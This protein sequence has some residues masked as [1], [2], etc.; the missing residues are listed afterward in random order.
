MINLNPLKGILFIRCHGVPEAIF[1]NLF[2]STAKER[3]NLSLF[4]YKVF[5]NI[6]SCRLSRADL[7]VS[8]G[9]LVLDV[10][11]VLVLEPLPLLS[12]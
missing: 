11:D 1:P 7:V 10:L 4:P 12:E 6:F 8:I 2:V 9:V 5:K 3:S